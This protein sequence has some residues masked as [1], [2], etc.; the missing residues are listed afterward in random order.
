MKSDQ[1]E[2]KE[3]AFWTTRRIITT[4]IAILLLLSGG[5]VIFTSLKKDQSKISSQGDNARTG[6]PIPL[7]K[8]GKNLSDYPDFEFQSLAGTTFRLSQYKGKVIILDFW[9]TW[10]IPCRKE[11]PQLVRIYDQN[12][13]KG[14]VVIG[15]HVD[16]QGQT[17]TSDIFTFTEEYK[18]EYITGWASDEV[19]T[20][21]LKE[22]DAIP[23]TLV[24]DR[25]GDL[26]LH[27][28]GYGAGD[29]TRLDAI[30]TSAINQQSE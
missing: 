28:V 20:S 19:F 25:D 10:C 12:R 11:I 1:S 8:S 23:Q 6:S 26:I 14:L 16:D 27:L 18:I 5:Y 21:F 7:Q 22:E 9:A 24:F 15:L 29:T 17:T 13:D 3:P 30:V 2:E 4:T